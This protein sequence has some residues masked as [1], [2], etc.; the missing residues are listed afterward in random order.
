MKVSLYSEKARRHIVATRAF[1][2]EKGYGASPEDIRGCRR[3]I[4]L[5][6][7][8][9]LMAKVA[10]GPDFFS[11]SPC[12]D[13]IF[14]VQEKRFTIPELETAIRSLGLEFLG[15]EHREPAVEETFRQAYP[16][17]GN[18]RSLACWAE[19]ED[20]YPDTFAEMYNF[21]VRRAQPA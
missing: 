14:H 9:P 13:L 8:D 12:R 21:W 2:A 5:R 3:E 18:R 17:A 19:F 20:C 6:A 7:D 1:A 11:L 4:L 16:G 10:A 15:F